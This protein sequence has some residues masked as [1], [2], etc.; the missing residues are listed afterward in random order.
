MDRGE[1]LQHSDQPPGLIPCW[2]SV[3]AQERVRR[4]QKSQG[5]MGVN[6]CLAM[7]V[8]MLFLLV[9]AALGIGAYQLH[10]MQIELGGMREVSAAI[11]YDDDDDDDD[12]LLNGEESLVKKC[13]EGQMDTCVLGDLKKRWKVEVV[14]TFRCLPPLQNPW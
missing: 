5:F 8:L 3:P 6:C 11:L 9:F 12:I 1:R 10:N 7:I 14:E 13:H 4:Q 2:S